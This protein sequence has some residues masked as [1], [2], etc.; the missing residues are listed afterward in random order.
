MKSLSRKRQVLAAFYLNESDEMKKFINNAED[1]TL[2]PFMKGEEKFETKT[3]PAC[4]NKEWISVG[5]AKRC[6]AVKVAKR[7]QSESGDY[8]YAEHLVQCHMR[9][10]T[11]IDGKAFCGI[12]AKHIGK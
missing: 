10:S 4:K 12:H 5:G 7:L 8:I 9:A 11:E 3:C 1:V 2:K 6:Q